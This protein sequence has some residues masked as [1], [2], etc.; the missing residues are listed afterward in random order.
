MFRLKENWGF[1][2]YKFDNADKLF[3]QLRKTTDVT[4]YRTLA[5]QIFHT[6]PLRDS[7]DSDW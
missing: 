4:Q 5:A 3:K 1:L 6:C 7:L 2:H